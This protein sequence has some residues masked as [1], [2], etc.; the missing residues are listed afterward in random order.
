MSKLDIV[1]AQ[2]AWA[3]HNLNNAQM[4]GYVLIGEIPREPSTIDLSII[5]SE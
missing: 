4:V 1:A 2:A 3:E 5:I